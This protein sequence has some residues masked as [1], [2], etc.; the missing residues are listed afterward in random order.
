MTMSLR[1]AC[2]TMPEAQR[3]AWLAAAERV[4][5][6][7]QIVREALGTS[8]HGRRRRVVE[9]P[10]G[11]L[12][13]L[14]YPL[15]TGASWTLR[16]EPFHITER[17]E[18]VDALHTPAGTLVGYRITLDF[19]LFGPPDRVTVWYGRK[20]YLGLE[21]HFEAEATDESG[22]PIGLVLT[23]QSETVSA[24]SSTA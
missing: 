17:V 15:H 14:S 21:A 22:N 3:A 10:P 23:D 12:L 16:T 7:W 6:R 20:G 11:E 24:L 5:R 13:R 8:G 19:E 1:N 4:E 2:S 18:G 9:P